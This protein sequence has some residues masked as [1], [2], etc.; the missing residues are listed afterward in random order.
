M[1][2]TTRSSIRVKPCSLRTRFR[3]VSIML[4]RTPFRGSQMASALDRLRSAGPRTPHGQRTRTGS[5]SGAGPRRLRSEPACPSLTAAPASESSTRRSL[6][7]MP[8][9]WDAGSARL[10]ET[11]GFEAL[12]TTSAGFAWSLGK[13]DQKVTRD[14]L[15][16]HVASLTAVTSVPLN[17]DSERLYPDDAGGVA[18]TVRLLGEAG[19]P[20][21][22]S[23]TTTRRRRYGR[24]RDGRRA[25]GGGRGRCA[26]ARDRA[27]RP[28]REPHPRRRRPRRHDRAA[29]RLP[30]CGRRLP[31][32]TRAHRPR[33]DRAG[34]RRAGIPSNVL[35]LSTVPP[36]PSSRGRRAPGLHGRPARAVP[37]PTARSPP[38]R[39]SSATAGRRATAGAASTTTRCAARSASALVQHV[40][41][42][43]QDDDDRA[44]RPRRGRRAAQAQL[45]VGS[46]A[47]PLAWSRRSTS[48]G[49]RP[50]RGRSRTC[51]A[52]VADHDERRRR[53]CA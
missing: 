16:A 48:K 22:R 11:L 23:R 7:L 9:P 14:E 18:E 26:R 19:A 32:R 52:P 46:V 45:K 21:S 34:R 15:V 1:M 20:G 13:L 10:L 6:F 36:S 25:C 40:V 43:E 44:P 39:T 38:P 51:S 4:G 12:A 49:G 50:G 5:A 27:D 47:H 28:C 29:R 42:Q 30:R 24:R 31:V 8:N 41:E 35:A 53:R 37:A 17:V 33:A 2:M 3:N